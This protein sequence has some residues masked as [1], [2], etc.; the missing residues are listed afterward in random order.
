MEMKTSPKWSANASLWGN[1]TSSPLEIVEIENPFIAE[2]DVWTAEKLCVTYS[3]VLNPGKYLLEVWGAK[4]GHHSSEEASGG[5]Y[6]RGE[7]VLTTPTNIFAVAGSAGKSAGS[8]NIAQGGCNGGGNGVT[9][10]GYTSGGGGASH[11]SAIKN[12]LAYR[13][14]VAGG[15]GGS[16][17]SGSCPVKGGEGGGEEGSN[18]YLCRNN[19]LANGMGANQVRPGLGCAK[20]TLNQCNAGSFGKGGDSSIGT[21]CGGGGGWWGGASTKQAVSVG[22]GGGSGFIFN[23]MKNTGCNEIDNHPLLGLINYVQKGSMYSGVNIGDGKVSITAI[24]YQPVKQDK[25]CNTGSLHTYIVI[26]AELITT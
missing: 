2:G 26:L 5:G 16:Y 7:L 24:K 23:G 10:S 13:I 8:G 25:S 4:G 12:D 21:G 3:M 1:F 11:I 19:D 20:G 6:S 9:G 15:A 17:Y 14:I 22:A 18:G